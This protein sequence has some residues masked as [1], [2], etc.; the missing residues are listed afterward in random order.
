MNLR[1]IIIVIAVAALATA[2]AVPVQAAESTK[3]AKTPAEGSFD[4][5]LDPSAFAVFQRAGLSI[6]SI[7]GPRVDLG[8]SGDLGMEFDVRAVD[9]TGR[10]FTDGGEA[11]IIWWNGPPNRYFYIGSPTLIGDSREGTISA[12]VSTGSGPNSFD[13]GRTTLFDVDKRRSI[14][15][16]NGEFAYYQYHL[17]LHD[18][19]EDVL[20]SALG[21]SVFTSKMRLGSLLLNANASA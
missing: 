17:K 15:Q 8:D 7:G 3:T 16:P 19:V 21:T 2:L 1:S 9:D 18:G 11:S 6:Y 12:D 5:I 13:L 14:K 10:T 20:N 4:L